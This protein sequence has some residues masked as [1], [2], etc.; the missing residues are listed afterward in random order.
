MKR[1]IMSVILALSMAM[2]LV[3]CN[4]N[5]PS[6]G[7][8]SSASGNTGSTETRLLT[9]GTATTGGGWYPM[10]GALAKILTSYM[11][12]ANV[13]AIATNASLENLSSLESSKLEIGMANS[14]VVYQRLHAINGYEAYK[15]DLAT[16]FMMDEIYVTVVVPSKSPCKTFQDLKGKKV[17]TGT[18]GSGFY[19]MVEA[20]LNSYGW[21]YDDIIPYQ[22]SNGD[23]AEA[24]KDGNI[25]AYCVLTPGKYGPSA[26]FVELMTTFD[27]RLLPFDDE[28][29][30]S[31]PAEKPFYNASAIPAGWY[32]GLEEDVPTFSVNTQ[33]CVRADM[34]EQTAYEITKAVF[35][36]VDELAEIHPNWGGL[37]LDLGCT[38]M[39]LPAHPGAEKY[40][41]EQGKTV[42]YLD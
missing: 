5:S 30:E 20:I 29:L 42:T 17:G 33:V 24:L 41:T 10:G 1:R 40:Y 28:Q 23:Q 6:P 26:G 14:D 16:L 37:T 12:N 8:S 19:Y 25:D 31:L 3:S 34:D 4:S 32:D 36:H 22:A 18:A 15:A 9:I 2:C 39:I 21:T 35:E 13:T 38:N 7:A 11:P 27:C